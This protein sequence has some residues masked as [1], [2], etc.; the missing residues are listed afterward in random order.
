[1][2]MH[3]LHSMYQFSIAVFIYV[4]VWMHDIYNYMQVKIKVSMGAWQFSDKQ[5]E[6]NTGSNSQ[7]WKNCRILLNLKINKR[8]PDKILINAWPPEVF[9]IEKKR[10]FD[11]TRKLTL[12]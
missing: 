3:M 9:I 10:S 5:N 2:C 4:Y 6:R 11:E 7:F 8:D 1:M 12:L